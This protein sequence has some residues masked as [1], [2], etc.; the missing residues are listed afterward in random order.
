MHAR[1]LVDGSMVELYV[2]D[3]VSLTSRAYPVNADAQL[4]RV[5]LAR[6]A[7]LISLSAHELHPAY[8]PRTAD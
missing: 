8:R 3:R 5:R 1:L 2:D 6:G 4:V 7:R